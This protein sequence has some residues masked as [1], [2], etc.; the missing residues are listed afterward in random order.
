VLAVNTTVIALVAPGDA[1]PLASVRATNIRVYRSDPEASLLDRAVAAC[2]EAGHTAAPY[3]LHDADPLAAVADAWAAR[4]DGTGVIGDLEIAVAA[5]ISRWR[6]R[7]LDL[8][9]YYLIADPE[10]YGATLRHWYLGVLAAAAPSRVVA[11]QPSLAIAD[12]LPE[13]STGPWWPSLDRLLA[14]ID[15]VVPDQAGALAAPPPQ[16]SLLRLTPQHAGPGT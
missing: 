11:V 3:L 5:T 1:S 8:P 7:A 15:R 9:D 6:A 10:G 14:G 4:F 12:Q 2:E 13:L 16:P